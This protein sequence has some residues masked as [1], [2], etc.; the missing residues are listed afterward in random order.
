MRTGVRCRRRRRTAHVVQLLTT[1]R[2]GQDLPEEVI[3]AV[4]A[5]EL[6]P[7]SAVGEGQLAAVAGLRRHVVLWVRE[8]GC[9]GGSFG[10]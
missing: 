2:P 8:E 10:L 4:N 6:A 3:E 7:D 9:G 1:H 5:V